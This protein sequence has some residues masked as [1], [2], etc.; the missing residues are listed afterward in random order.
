MAH[1]H[2]LAGTFATACYLTGTMIQDVAILTHADHIAA[3]WHP[4]KDYWAV[5]AFALAVN[6]AGIHSPISLV[7]ERFSG[8]GFA[9][10]ASAA[11]HRIVCHSLLDCHLRVVVLPKAVFSVLLALIPIGSA[12]AFNDRCAMS[13][14]GLY[15]LYILVAGLLLWRHLGNDVWVPAYFLIPC[16]ADIIPYLQLQI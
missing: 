2:R 13:I 3:S 1:A 11:G 5:V 16:D 9:E 6:T 15:L 10:F 12:V 7:E 8:D 4:T 14:S